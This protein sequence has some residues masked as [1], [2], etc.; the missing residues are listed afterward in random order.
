[1]RIFKSLGFFL[2]LTVL[3]VPAQVD[4]A[5]N[6]EY[7]YFTVE[8]PGYSYVYLGYL[9]H[10][11]NENGVI[12]G[13]IH[14]GAGY[15][16][17]F[18]KEPGSGTYTEFTDSA[19]DYAHDINNNFDILYSTRH[20]GG[21]IYPSTLELADG[22]RV[23]FN[24]GDLGSDSIV[25][26]GL[27]DN[28]KVVGYFNRGGGTPNTGFIWENGV[29]S[30]IQ[31]PEGADQVWIYDINNQDQIAGFYDLLGNT[32][33]RIG[34]VYFNDQYYLFEYPGSPRTHAVGINDNGQVVG[35][36][37]NNKIS[38][39]FLYDLNQDQ[40]TEIKFPGAEITFAYSINNNGEIAGGYQKSGKRYAFLAVPLQTNTPP[41]ADAGDNLQID[42]VDFFSTVIMGYAE[43]EDNDQ[44]TYRWVEG[45]EVLQDWQDVG[46]DGQAYLDLG[47]LPML[48]LVEHTLT[49][50]VSDGESDSMDSMILSVGN[51]S[52]T[53]AASGS[54]V[55]GLGADITLGGQLSDYDGDLLTYQWTLGEE[56]LFYGTVVAIEGGDP[57]PLPSEIISN[58]S[59]GAHILQ[60]EVWDEFNSPVTSEI[61]VEIVDAEAPTL[62][63]TANPS[64]LWPPN[65]KMVDVV[66]SADAQDNSGLAPY[67]TVDVSCDEESKR[68]PWT[69]PVIDQA[70]GVIILGLLAERSGK[71]DGRVYTITIT[72]EDESGNQSSASVEVKAPHDQGRHKGKKKGRK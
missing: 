63:P 12:V 13:N 61:M 40:F 47:T 22:Q 42:S 1:M 5:Q 71:G 41:E 59:L 65:H 66:I 31:S 50:V 10:G 46:P 19:R 17:G 52:P 8:L 18:V 21:Q 24:R 2:I 51:S 20:G 64:I 33:I 54:G 9:A 67:L 49:L 37:E 56:I 60:L 6:I 32:A 39:G 25:A 45:D 55:Y 69:E 34:F 28:L 26:T 15:H 35:F 16:N 44:L 3:A 58:L 38:T 72:A 4:A 53:V 57:V 30:V 23:T 11:I 27:N 48:S 43:D 68:T 62:S 7:Q 70:E 14:R 29:Y 36:Y